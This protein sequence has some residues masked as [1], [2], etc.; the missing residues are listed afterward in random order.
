M[1]PYSKIRLDSPLPKDEPNKETSKTSG[2][3]P[4]SQAEL[5]GVSVQLEER[6]TDDVPKVL[7]RHPAGSPSRSSP[8]DIIE[9][10]TS[11]NKT[12]LEYSNE[13]VPDAKKQRVEQKEIPVLSDSLRRSPP[14]V[15]ED[16]TDDDD[17]LPDIVD[18][19]PDEDDK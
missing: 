11:K 13:A 17:F 19:G 18:C 6:V 5:S 4:E 8:V 10:Q 1:A 16:D 12:S 2:V 7:P 9:G 15:N 14:K 3:A